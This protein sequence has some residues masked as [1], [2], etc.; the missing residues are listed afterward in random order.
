MHRSPLITLLAVG[1]GLGGLLLVNATQTSE[2]TAADTPA[3]P[4]TTA[5]TTAP[6]AEPTQAPSS[7][8]TEVPSQTPSATETPSP[9]APPKTTPPAFPSKIVYA[10]RTV[11]RRASV[12]IAV[13][14]GRS[15]AYFCDGRAVEAWFTGTAANGRIALRS[16]KGD[17]IQ[18]QLEGADVTGAVRIGARTFRFTVG[19]AEPPA[20]LYR[21]RGSVN[22][23]TTTI[24]WIVL[25]DGSQV[26]ISSDGTTAKTAPRLKPSDGGVTV[27]GV[28]IEARTVSGATTF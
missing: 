16:K 26:G 18:A 21:G 25:P 2:D 4:A 3:G 9:T 15:A 12:A 7:E 19:K 20:G 14:N 8:P 6:S 13:L 5:P 11:D 1:A 24:G 23:R 27:D 22:G 10:G 28:R 17:T